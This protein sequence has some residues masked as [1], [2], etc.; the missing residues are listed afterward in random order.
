MRG[1]VEV[2]RERD[3]RYR[4]TVWLDDDELGEKMGG[5]ANT[6]WDAAHTASQWIPE[7]PHIA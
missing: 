6:K 4:W 7:R 1:R 5:W 2:E 3:G